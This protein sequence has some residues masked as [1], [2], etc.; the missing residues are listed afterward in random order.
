MFNEEMYNK[1]CY[2]SSN[3]EDKKNQKRITIN[4]NQ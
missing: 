2:A 4:I 1:F 3:V